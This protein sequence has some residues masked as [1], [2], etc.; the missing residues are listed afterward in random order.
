MLEC[1]RQTKDWQADLIVFPEM[2]S[3]GFSVKDPG[4]ADIEGLEDFISGIVTFL[5][6]Y[7]MTVIVGHVE[8]IDN[9]LQNVLYAIEGKRGVL[10]RY[11]KSHSF[12]YAGEDELFQSDNSLQIVRVGEGTFG[13]SICYD[14][15]FPELY[16]QYVK[17]GASA[18][19]VIANW[20]AVRKEHW[21]TLLKARAIENQMF[22]IGVN[23]TGR[24]GLDIEY[25]PSSAIYD[26]LGKEL[27][28]K[29]R[30]DSL[31]LYELDFTEV[32]KARKTMPVL[33]DMIAKDFGYSVVEDD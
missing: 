33:N 28:P 7:D 1:I 2:M 32:A 8:K 15:R 5:G 13:L 22:V 20:P 18:A 16:R 29:T 4:L 6:D 31:S 23:R 9:R 3:T 26:P 25:D 27:A 19:I 17:A 12:S 14:L 21:Q 30:A 10:C 11:V 24:D